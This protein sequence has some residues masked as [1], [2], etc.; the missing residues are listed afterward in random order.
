[1][2]GWSECSNDLI[3]KEKFLDK[4]FLSDRGWMTA[5]APRHPNKSEHREMAVK[6]YDSL[7][8]LYNI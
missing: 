8:K 4:E 3:R 2:F 7:K 1:M 6:L 5:N